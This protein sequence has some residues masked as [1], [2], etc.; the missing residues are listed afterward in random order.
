VYSLLLLLQFEGVLDWILEKDTT[1]QAIPARNI[2]V[3]PPSF[4][5]K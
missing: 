3:F 1:K 2:R 5:A 4:K